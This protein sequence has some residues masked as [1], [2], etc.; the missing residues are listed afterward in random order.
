[1]SKIGVHWGEHVGIKNL[2]VYRMR[3]IIPGITI[4]NMGSSFRYP[5]RIQL[6]FT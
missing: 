6:P 5:H 4:L 3:L 1:M 2:P